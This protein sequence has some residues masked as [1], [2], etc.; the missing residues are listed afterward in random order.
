MDVFFMN[1]MNCCSNLRGLKCPT[2]TF[3]QTHTPMFDNISIRFQPVSFNQRYDD[4][5]MQARWM[6]FYHG[7]VY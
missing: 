7:Y 5:V 4:V 6:L 2:F 3:T 1:A